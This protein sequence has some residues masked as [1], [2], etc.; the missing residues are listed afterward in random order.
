MQKYII[1]LYSNYSI[2]G[3]SFW[4]VSLFSIM[5]LLKPLTAF[6]GGGGGGGGGGWV[7]GH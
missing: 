7:E 5:R 3:R 4:F 6:L 2:S 1:I